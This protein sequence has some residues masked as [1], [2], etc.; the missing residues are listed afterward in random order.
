MKDSEKIGGIVILILT[1]L[2]GYYNISLF[3]WGGNINLYVL[4][5]GIFALP[6]FHKLRV[7][8]LIPLIILAIYFSYNLRLQLIPI[9]KNPNYFTNANPVQQFNQ[10]S[11]LFFGGVGTLLCVCT[12][13]YYLVKKIWVLL[14][15]IALVISFAVNIGANYLY[16]TSWY[17][18]LFQEDQIREV[19]LTTMYARVNIRIAILY[20]LIFLLLLL[21]IK[22]NYKEKKEPQVVSPE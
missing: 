22:P 17:W 3:S 18:N 20:H 19:G 12:F 13:L 2:Y 6:F 4:L 5:I 1:L 8:L 16:F 9:L 11:F 10:T 7:L 14:P 15:A 21:F